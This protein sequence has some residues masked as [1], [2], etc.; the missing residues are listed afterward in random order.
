MASQAFANYSN[1]AASLR[2]TLEGPLQEEGAEKEDDMK[3][4]KAE[5]LS[6]S[7]M[8]AKEKFI[9]TA[10][11]AFKGL[12]PVQALIKRTT[13]I[14]TTPLRTATEEA[15]AAVVKAK[16]GTD[17]EGVAAQI[18][19]SARGVQG[20]V[21]ELKRVSDAAQTLKE[22]TQASLTEAQGDLAEKTS[23]L[24]EQ[25]TSA[26]QAQSLFE[27]KDAAARAL[28]GRGT[29]Q[30]DAIQSAVNDEQAASK[31]ALDT[32]N[33]RVSN[34]SGDVDA[35][36]TKVQ[37]LQE[38]FEQHSTAAATSAEE[39]TA[40]TTA[41][42][43]SGVEDAAKAVRIEKTV[44][45]LKDTEEAAGASE[46]L[47]DPFGALIAGAVAGIT[48]LLGSRVHVHTVVQPPPPNISQLASYSVTPGA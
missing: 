17:A 26:V 12:K 46:E 42:A 5:V 14:D 40:A 39:T 37:D 19:R 13:G 33:A 48:Y 44:K 1:Q 29:S 23:T 36:T 18:A 7:S 9:E 15:A 16:A 38:Q 4:F 47:G 30:L 34:A 43:A 45:D 8:F 32:A 25:Q 21:V 11:R 28:Q 31:A 10:P 41:D 20:N 35:A 24:A 2:S 27:E 3:A 6:Q 22:Q